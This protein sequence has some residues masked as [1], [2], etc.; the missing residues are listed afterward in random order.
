MVRS[1]V[2]PL[3]LVE[4]YRMLVRYNALANR[5]LYDAC[6]RLSDAERKRPRAAFPGS[7]RG[8]LNHTMVGDR[9]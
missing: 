3:S 4:N 6:A 2:A 9:I 1:A 5:R 7:I 8:M